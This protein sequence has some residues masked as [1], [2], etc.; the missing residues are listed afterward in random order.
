M[1][2]KNYGRKGWDAKK[3]VVSLKAFDAKTNW[4]AVKTAVGR[5]GGWREMGASLRGHGLWSNGTFA[6]E[7]I[8]KL[9]SEDNDWGHKSVCDSDLWS[10][11]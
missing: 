9:R 10:V 2:R 3:K 1:L 6:V 7:S 5:V 11:E 4:L 8:T